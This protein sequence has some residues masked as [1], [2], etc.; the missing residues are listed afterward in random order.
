MGWDNVLL[1]LIARNVK[2]TS[3]NQNRKLKQEEGENGKEEGRPHKQSEKIGNAGRK[4]TGSA[5]N[6]SNRNLLW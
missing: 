4:E 3:S 2:F 6:C 1:K 5:L